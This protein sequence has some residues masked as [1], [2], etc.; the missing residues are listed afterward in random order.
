MATSKQSQKRIRTS[1]KARIA[2]KGVRGAMKT[3][4]KRVSA[5]TSAGD[6]KTALAEA[7]KRVDKAA[8]SGVIHKNTAAR[9]KSQLARA[10]AKLK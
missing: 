10:A 1:E 9:K 4:A 2:N 5:A 6:A 7:M 3:A 8:K